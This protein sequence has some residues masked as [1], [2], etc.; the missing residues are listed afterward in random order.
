M[1]AKLVLALALGHGGSFHL[2]AQSSSPD[3]QTQKSSKEDG[4]ALDREEEG[5]RKLNHKLPTRAK[6][7]VGKAHIIPG[8]TDQ[9][10]LQGCSD[11]HLT[12]HQVRNMFR[13]YHVVIGV[14]HEGYSEI[15]CGIEGDIL[16]DGR[17]YIFQAQP[18]NNLYTDWPNG[19][20]H[21]LGGK[22]SSG[23]D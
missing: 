23:S 12:E 1:V 21:R 3:A 4:A 18:L 14:E 15:G 6:I 13:S 17:R 7:A 20:Y 19:T 10:G 22:Q 16:V 8:Y 9:E 11:W 2:L 5:L